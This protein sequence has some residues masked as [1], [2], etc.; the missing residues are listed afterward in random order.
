MIQRHWIHRWHNLPWRVSILAN[1][2]DTCLLRVLRVNRNHKW[3]VA[4]ATRHVHPS[5]TR[6]IAQSRRLLSDVAFP[7]GNGNAPIIRYFQNLQVVPFLVSKI[8]TSLVD[9]SVCRSAFYSITF[10]ECNQFDSSMYT[11]TI[12]ISKINHRMWN[13][14]HYTWK[15]KQTNTFRTQMYFPLIFKSGFWCFNKLVIFI[16]LIN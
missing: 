16:Y 9:I 3:N 13:Q 8:A 7:S 4:H 11:V 12:D 10:Y 5:P 1:Y 14:R 15:N 2:A 6:L